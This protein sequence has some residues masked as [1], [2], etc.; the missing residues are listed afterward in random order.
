MTR[1]LAALTFHED[2]NKGDR[3]HHCPAQKRKQAEQRRSEWVVCSCLS[4]F[5]LPLSGRLRENHSSAGN[6]GGVHLSVLQQQ[7]SDLRKCRI[8]CRLG[9]AYVPSVIS[10][11]YKRFFLLSH[12]ELCANVLSIS[13]PKFEVRCDSSTSSGALGN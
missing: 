8:I 4:A 9:F 5:A 6:D 10:P 12:C 1:C 7:Q 11:G 13:H 3:F 2:A